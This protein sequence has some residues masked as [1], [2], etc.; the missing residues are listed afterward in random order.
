MAKKRIPPLQFEIVQERSNLLFLSVIEYKR[1]NYL[2]IIDNISPYEITAFVLDYAEQEG[3]N[4]KEF[5][6]IANRWYYGSS[7][8]HPFSVEIAKHNLTNRIGQIIKTF[9]VGFIS[10]VVGCPFFYNMMVK[11]VKRRR[12]VAIPEGVE[13]KFKKS[14]TL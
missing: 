3:I 7:H 1:E 12:V 6:S 11:K 13:I 8:K 4:I 10:R 9:D 14:P 2:T 5:L